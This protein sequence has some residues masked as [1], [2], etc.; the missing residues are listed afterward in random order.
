M[1]LTFVRFIALPRIAFRNSSSLIAAS[2]DTLASCHT[3]RGCQAGSLE[4]GAIWFHG[5]TSW[6]TSQP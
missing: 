5:Q 4:P 6:H 1:P 3:G 2:A